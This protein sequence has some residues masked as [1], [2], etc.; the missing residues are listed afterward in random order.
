MV[1]Y[2]KVA[3]NMIYSYLFRSQFWISDVA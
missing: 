3:F 1:E 2:W